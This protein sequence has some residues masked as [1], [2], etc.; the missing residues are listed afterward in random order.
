MLDIPY[1][2]IH[3]PADNCVH[4]YLEKLIE[5]NKDKLTTLQDIMNVLM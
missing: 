2:G 5:N 3:T 4:K 1:M